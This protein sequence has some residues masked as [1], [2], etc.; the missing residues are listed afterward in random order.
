MHHGDLS[1]RAA[2]AQRARCAAQTLGGFAEG[3]AV[4]CL[5]GRLT[6]LTIV[7]NILHV[8]LPASW[9]ANCASRRSHRGTSGRRR[10]RASARPQA[11]PDRPCTCAKAPARRPAV[12]PLPARGQG[13]AVSAPRTMVARRSSGSVLSPNS[14]TMMSKVHRLAAVAPEHILDVEGRS[15]EALRDRLHLRRGDEQEDRR[16][17]DKAAD[18]PGA[19]DAVDFRAALASPTPCGLAAS[20]LRHP[21]CGTSGKLGPGPGLEAA[22]Q[23]VRTAPLHDAARRRR[24]RL[25][26]W[27]F[28]QMTMAER[29]W[30][31]P[32]PCG[33][34]GVGVT[35]GAGDQARDRRRNPR[36]CE[37]RSGRDTSACRSAGRVYQR[38]WSSKK[39]WRVLPLIGA[40]TRCF[41]M[42]PR[43][44][45]AFPIR[46]L[47][48]NARRLCQA[49]GHFTSVYCSIGTRMPK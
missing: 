38:R 1:G 23:H 41:G 21:G 47:I 3:D 12:P 33:H 19:G 11:A 49:K 46:C 24:R 27:P 36:P 45:I 42:S 4:P 28:W 10:R 15:V 20:R 35:H 31:S 6:C 16:R 37:R 32:G 22:F 39:T 26:F 40:G 14:S 13:R 48:T 43:G 18:Q 7:E 25:S 2:E 29:P 9:T 17:I 8:T 30:N 5:S 44:E 34:I